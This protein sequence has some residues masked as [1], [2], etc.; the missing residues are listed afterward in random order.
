MSRK[1]SLPKGCSLGEYNGKPTIVYDNGSDKPPSHAVG[2]AQAIV[3]MADAGLDA[4][5]ISTIVTKLGCWNLGKSKVD[6]TLLVKGAAYLVAHT[7][8]KKKAS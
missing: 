5:Q 2:K 1:L 8:S 4:E 7:E 3:M 6:P